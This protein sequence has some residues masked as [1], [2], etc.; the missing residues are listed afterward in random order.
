MFEVEVRAE[1][2]VNGKKHNLPF[3]DP[4]ACKGGYNLTCPLQPGSVYNFE[5]AFYIP[6]DPTPVYPISLLSI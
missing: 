1:A 2:I 3:P 6:N 5:A 4:N